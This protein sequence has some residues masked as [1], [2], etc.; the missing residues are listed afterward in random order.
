MKLA[1]SIFIVSCWFAMGF[2]IGYHQDREATP[3][4]TLADWC[5][6]MFL[7]KEET[8]NGYVYFCTNDYGDD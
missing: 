3:N 1:F 5:G 2:S 6:D 4:F 8:E 7:A